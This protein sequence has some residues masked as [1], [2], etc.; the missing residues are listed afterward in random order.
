MSAKIMLIEDASAA[1]AGIRVI[2]HFIKIEK[3]FFAPAVKSLAPTKK[4]IASA[5]KFFTP[6]IHH[7]ILTR[8]TVFH[9]QC[10]HCGF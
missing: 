2:T 6:A 4:I 1:S 10:L 5:I 8:K 3:N 9:I 7:A